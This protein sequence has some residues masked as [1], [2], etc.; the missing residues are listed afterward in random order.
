MKVKRTIAKNRTSRFQAVAKSYQQ[1][2]LNW[3]IRTMNTPGTG[4]KALWLAFM[5]AAIMGCAGD[6]QPLVMQEV[7]EIEATVTAIDVATRMVVLRGPAGNE[8]T[9]Q[10]DPEVRNLAQVNVGDKLKITYTQAFVASMADPAA[11]SS[12]DTAVIGIGAERAAEGEMPGG[13]VGGMIAATVEIISVGEG[14]AT[15][16][17][18][19]PAG[20]L[21]SIDILR[22]EAREFASK[23]RPGDLVDMTYAEAVA[24]EV[25]H[26]D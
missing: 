12:E 3:R 10:V 16:T 6:P 24:V 1:V 9:I 5:L 19:G 7:E 21:R 20:E 8:I 4:K 23:L 17:F 2:T 26:V 13:T 11:A 18:R 25:E 15:L 22:E 14:G